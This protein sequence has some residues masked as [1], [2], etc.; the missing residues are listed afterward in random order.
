[1]SPRI[2]P[3]AAARAGRPRI[4]DLPRLAVAVTA[5][6]AAAGGDTDTAIKCVLLLAP[7]VASR[8]VAVAPA[9]EVAFNLALAGEAIGSAA[10]FNDISGWNTMAH[11]VLPSLSGPF[12]YCALERV[13]LRTVRTDGR[14][15]AATGTGLAAGIVTFASVLA[16]GALWELVEWAVDTWFGTQFAIS[17]GDTVGDLLH[18]AVAALASGLVVALRGE[19]VMRECH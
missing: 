10:G 5:I 12:L 13:G 8:L 18:D 2:L 7:A 3:S 1:M 6:A 14:A 16:I 15:S 19:L 17:Y 4:A 11:L 9:W